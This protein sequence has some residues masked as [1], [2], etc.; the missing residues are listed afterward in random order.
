MSLSQLMYGM[1]LPT[2]LQGLSIIGELDSGKYS[3][4]NIFKTFAWLL[5]TPEYKSFAE[6]NREARKLAELEVHP[7]QVT[8]DA[9]M[10]CVL[11][12]QQQSTET[13]VKSTKALKK[14]DENCARN[15]EMREQL[16]HLQRSVERLTKLLENRS[17]E[18]A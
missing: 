7:R 12:T 18:G 17:E 11:V 14:A 8:L 4:S 15:E 10:S 9:I 5:D 1:I 6:S 13:A 3:G 2:F 16:A